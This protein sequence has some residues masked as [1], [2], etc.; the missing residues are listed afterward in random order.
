[1]KKTLHLFFFLASLFPLFICVAEL[2]LSL[3]QPNTSRI[4]V[5]A[6]ASPFAS[7]LK[8]RKSG[9]TILR[10]LRR[11]GQIIEDPEINL[12]I[13]SIG[14]RLVS[15]ALQST[16]PFYFLISKDTSINAFATEGGVIVV[17]AG[18]ILRSGSESEVAAVI[19]HEIA[20]V[21]QRHI[22]RMR[23][24]AKANKLGTNAALIAGMVASTQNPQAG[25]AILN[26]TIATMAHNQLSFS[27]EAESEA[28]R[29][30]LRILTRA[31][32]DPLA[33]PSILQKL[34]QF[35][36]TGNEEI[37]ELLQKH[38]LTHRR[39]TDTLSRAKKIGSFRG[40]ESKHY[41]F[42]FMREKIRANTK[43]LLT[44]PNKVPAHIKKYSIAQ[45][46]MQRK[47]FIKALQVSN[48]KGSHIPEALMVAQL[49]CK[50][51]QFKKSLAILQPLYGL[52]P[53]HQ[54]VILSLAKT[55][56]ALGMHQKAWDTIKHI[57]PL[58]QTSLEFFEVKQSIAQQ[59]K[60]PS[61]AYYASALRNIRMANYKIAKTQIKKAIKL[62]RNS[63]EA[64][65]MKQDL[66]LLDGF[67]KKK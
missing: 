54:P 40:K 5:S 50:T 65:K 39:V 42:M 9:L 26:T 64:R 44:T 19:A 14:N 48:I 32:F 33:M 11:T 36:I 13:R 8:A 3:P 51:K 1:M 21:T 18:L 16:S 29:E 22:S 47:S 62:S 4:Q 60:Q 35:A 27:R 15:R 53:S 2:N 30:G 6:A 12:W 31:G 24:K 37:R 46:L 52:Y 17:N 23:N 34:E 45:K 49:L 25:Q 61:Q 66:F 57:K 55:Y 41:L 20:H 56:S 38:P 28:D 10:K 58:E 63:H 59:A 43:T 67:M 7:T